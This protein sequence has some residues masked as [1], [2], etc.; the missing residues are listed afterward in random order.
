MAEIFNP[1]YRKRMGEV[2]LVLSFTASATLIG[3]IFLIIPAIVIGIAWGFATLLVVDKEINP[4]EAINKS[5][6]ITYGHKWTIFFGGLI[7]G[8][9]ELIG[10][11]IIIGLCYMLYQIN[12]ALAFLGGLIMIFATGLLISISAGVQAYIYGKLLK[13]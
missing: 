2:F 10:Y 5:N 13:E 8:I 1:I 4:I 6:S 9:L 7:V 12:H 11:G 3:L